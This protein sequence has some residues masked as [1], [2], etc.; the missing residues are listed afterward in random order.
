MSFIKDIL[1]Y[2]NKNT[3][4]YINQCRSHGRKTNIYVIRRDDKTGQAHLL[5]IIKWSGAWR[6][7]IIEYEPHTKW[8]ASCQQGIT[9]FLIKINKEWRLKWI[10]TT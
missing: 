8:S 5:G 3:K 2:K 10:K 1:I 4:V 9:D 6:Q 7:Y